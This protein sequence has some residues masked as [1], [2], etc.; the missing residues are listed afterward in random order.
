MKSENN[1]KRDPLFK[2]VI[3]FLNRIKTH[4]M[5]TKAELI[6][7]REDLTRAFNN[8]NGCFTTNEYMDL[9]YAISQ[10]IKKL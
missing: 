2:K 10:R 6:K 7:E 8:G 1:L 3:V 4:T 5:K 9:Y